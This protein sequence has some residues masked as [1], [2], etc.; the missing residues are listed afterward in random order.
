MMNNVQGSAI[1][2]LREDPSP[3]AKSSPTPAAMERQLNFQPAD[4]NAGK[5]FKL[6]SLSA[7]GM[8]KASSCIT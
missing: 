7:E 1:D 3:F 5:S 6:H 4:T 2:S 8:M